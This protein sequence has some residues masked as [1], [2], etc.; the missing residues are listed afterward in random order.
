MMYNIT[1]NISD[2]DHSLLVNNNNATK[3]L[4]KEDFELNADDLD[5]IKSLLLKLANGYIELADIVLQ[6]K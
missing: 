6:S 4:L 5:D 2:D 3:E 1:L